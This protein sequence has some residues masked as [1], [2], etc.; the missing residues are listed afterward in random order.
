MAVYHLRFAVV[1]RSKGQSVV[2]VAADRARM[3]L[4]D[5]RLGGT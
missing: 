1:Q 5:R 2:T 4:H 3:R